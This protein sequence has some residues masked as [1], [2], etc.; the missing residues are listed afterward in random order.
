MEKCAGQAAL[1]TVFLIGGVIV[2]FGISLALITLS[3]S[4]ATLGFH[5][6]TKA[7]ALS[8]GGVK[9]AEMQLIRDASFSDASGYCVPYAVP[10]CPA[11]TATVLVVQNSPAAG[12]VTVTADA[13][14]SMRHRKVRAVYSLTASTTQLTPVSFQELTL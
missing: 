2:L 9:D 11:G 14:V 13:V 6:A 3:F 8:V 1:S 10:P 4:G 12:E 7:L 5:A